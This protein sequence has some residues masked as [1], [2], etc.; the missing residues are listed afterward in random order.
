VAEGLEGDGRIERTADQ[1]ADQRGVVE[2]F[3]TSNHVFHELLFAVA[4]AGVG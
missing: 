1:G 2:V 3:P 4:D